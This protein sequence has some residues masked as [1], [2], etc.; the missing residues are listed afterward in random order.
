M[1]KVN[2]K[3]AYRSIESHP[4]N[5]SATGL[6][7]HFKNKPKPSYMYDARLPFWARKSPTIYHRLTQAVRR[8]M[9]RR[10]YKLLLRLPR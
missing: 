9:G 7:W 10:G 3:N 2:L 5:Y 1:A 6:A 8:E 4:L